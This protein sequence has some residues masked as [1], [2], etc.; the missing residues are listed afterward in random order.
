M[1]RKLISLVFLVVVA[2]IGFNVFFGSEEDKARG[3]AV[4]KEIKEL[5]GAV[6][7]FLKAEKENYDAGK[8]DD[9]VQKLKIVSQ[10]AQD[11]GSNLQERVK[12]LEDKKDDLDKLIDINKNNKMADPEKEKKKIDDEMKDILKE[13]QDIAT[14]IDRKQ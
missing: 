6:F 5:G 1:I 2:L 4:I 11:A 8:Y 10:K 3:N 12:E 7:G 9:I 13:L 14:D